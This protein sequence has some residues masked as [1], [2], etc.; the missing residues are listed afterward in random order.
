MSDIVEFISRPVGLDVATKKRPTLLYVSHGEMAY[1]WRMSVL[2]LLNYLSSLNCMQ[3]MSF[4]LADCYAWIEQ[5]KLQAHVIAK[6]CKYG[7]NWRDMLTSA[8]SWQNGISEFWVYW[9]QFSKCISLLCHAACCPRHFKGL[10]NEPHSL[11]VN[12]RLW[13]HTCYM[14]TAAC[15]FSGLNFYHI[16]KTNAWPFLDR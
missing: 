7:L 3:T 10:E 5:R 6:L 16:K 4:S 13:H 15:P 1:P 9:I 8:I 2:G 12:R 14:L 11:S